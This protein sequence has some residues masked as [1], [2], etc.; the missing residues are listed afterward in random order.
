MRMYLIPQGTMIWE[1][2]KEQGYTDLDAIITTVSGGGM[3]SGICIAAKNI[4]PK[5]KGTFSAFRNK[6]K[7]QHTIT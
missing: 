3:S 4:D 6:K 2:V 7:A 5:I 1:M